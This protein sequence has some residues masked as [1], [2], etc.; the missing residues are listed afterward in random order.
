MKG[1]IRERGTGNWYAVID[2]PDPAT[3]KRK[4]KWIAL[5]AKGKREAQIECA[6]IISEIDGGT[7]IDAK[8]ITV[9]QFLEQWLEHT[10]ASVS[11]R[12]FARYGEI[13]RKSIAPAIGN[14]TLA[15]LKP[16]QISTMYAKAL[17]SGRR[18]GKGG[19]SPRT[20]HHLH[21]V[22]KQALRQAV[23]WQM[24]VRNPVDA[25]DAPKVERQ[26]MQTFDM[27]QTAEALTLAKPHRVFVPAL[28]AALCGLRRGEVAALRWG[29]IDLDR[30]EASIVESA[31]QI[32]SVVRY[33]P[34]KSGRGRHIALPAYVVEELRAWRVRQ[35][36]ELLRLGV[37]PSPDT[38]IVTR[39]DGQPMQ[40]DS[41]TQQWDRFITRSELPQIRFHDLRHAHATHLLASGVNP[42]IA[43]ERLGHSKVQITLDLYSHV[44]PGMQEDA[45]S[46]VDAAFRAALNRKG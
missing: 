8:R 38:F 42:K 23:K 2:R 30:A 41:I 1:H 34:P 37:R 35:A 9:A 16:Q 11:P 12:T 17:T 40:P 29:R 43:S 39:E 26:T 28:L 21:R 22:T 25:V 14:V 33:K 45:V 10:K 3:G 6:R 36:Q 46:R 31:E 20:V 7:H 18:D 27:E 44:M 13:A 19:L 32:G 24:L 4:R 15:Q 5:D